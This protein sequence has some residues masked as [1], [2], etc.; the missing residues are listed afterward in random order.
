[1][2]RRKPKVRR[3]PQPPSHEIAAGF[4]LRYSQL[5][6]HKTA[7]KHG[8]STLDIHHAT[9]HAIQTFQY[10]D[11]WD[12]K[13]ILIIGPDRSGNMLELIA[14][15]RS[16]QTARIFHAIKLRPKFQNLINQRK[17]D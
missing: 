14:T 2:P 7:L 4:V 9:S 6:I 17:D 13:R 16:D 11:E 10:F 1:V 3:T 8:V 5:E 15:I 12:R